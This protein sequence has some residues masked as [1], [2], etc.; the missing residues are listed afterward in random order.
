M[1]DDLDGVIAAPDNH[2]V[3]FENDA[4]RVLETTIAAGEVTPLHTH[5]APTVMYVVCGSDFVRRDEHGATMVD[6]RSNPDFV[7]PKVLYAQTTPKH[8]IENTGADDLVVI[9]VELK[10][11]GSA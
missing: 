7:L 2:R 5:L 1:T 3:L 4:V 10:H 9:G 6:T 11:Q 8:T